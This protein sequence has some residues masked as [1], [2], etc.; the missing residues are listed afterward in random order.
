MDRP[1]ALRHQ[2]GGQAGRDT[3]W[4]S[5]LAEQPPKWLEPFGGTLSEV[6]KLISKYT[7]PAAN[8][9]QVTSV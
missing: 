4:L 8:T 3:R 1:P 6:K 7:G 2:H 9:T 5:F